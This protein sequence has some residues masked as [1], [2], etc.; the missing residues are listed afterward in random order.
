ML[1]WTLSVV[2]PAVMALNGGGFV[3]AVVSS[4]GIS[5]SMFAIW[6][7]ILVVKMAQFVLLPRLF[8]FIAS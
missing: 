2:Y 6:F 4:F 7:G 3:A 5:G 8:A 1:L